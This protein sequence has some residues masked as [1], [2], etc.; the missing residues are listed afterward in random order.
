MIGHWHSW[1]LN[2]PHVLWFPPTIPIPA[3]FT[4]VTSECRGLGVVAGTN[5]RF[6]RCLTVMAALAA[7]EVAKLLQEFGHRT[8]L[9]G[10]N[11]YRAKAYTRAAEN[12]LALTQPLQ[13][14]VAQERLT[15]IPGVGG[16]IAEIVTKLHLTGDHPSLRSMRKEIPSGV[17]E[18]LSIPGLRADKV[19][20]I[21]KELGLSSLDELE[22]AAREG[23]L[24]PVKGLGAALQSKILQGVEIRRQGEGKRHLHRAAKLLE[25][26]QDQ[27]RRSRLQ[28]KQLFPA[29][30]FRRGCELVSD[31]VLVAEANRS[32][33]KRQKL[34]PGAQLKVYV[35]DKRQLGATLLMATGSA[36]HIEQLRALAASQGML[37]D[38]AGLHIGKKVASRTE[39][40]IYQALGL[41]FIEPQLREGRG[42]IELARRGKLPKLVTDADIRGILHAHTV[43]SDGRD[44]LEVMAEATRARGFS[45]FGVADHS[46]SA[47]YAGGLSIDEITQQHAEAD[48]LNKRYG[49]RFRIFKGIESDILPDGSLDYPDHVLASFD[50]VVASVHSRFK[51]DGKEQTARL[52]RAV[53]NPRTTILGH[54]TGRQLLRRPG[55]DLDVEKVLVACAKHGVAVEINANPWRLDLDW[56]W[57]QRALDLGCMM[58][59]NP[60]AHSTTEID[61]THWGVEMARKGGIPSNRVLN[62]FDL[63]TFREFLKKR[64]TK[65]NQIAKRRTGR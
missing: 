20:K 1:R 49:S 33:G 24:K 12:L 52:V 30:D 51:L 64:H 54:M 4:A 23:R 31:L 48:A 41:P 15:E 43:G 29:G 42:E 60:D 9:R 6:G 36:T 3:K 61:L 55:Y 26:A 16:A 47:Q 65:A 11:P 10:G 25:T 22:K 40:D 39:E 27:L 35:T 14:L 56:R 7:S 28:I 50:F 32:V 38:E 53:A 57:H 19:L 18:M 34:N 17:L 37:L 46:Q 13:E 63:P 44:S 21:Y 8:A 5:G 62:C 59:I 58:S 45:Y 2:L